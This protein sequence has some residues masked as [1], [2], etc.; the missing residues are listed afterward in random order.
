LI[1]KITHFGETNPVR[2]AQ[3]RKSKYSQ[4]AEYNVVNRNICDV[5]K[6]YHNYYGCL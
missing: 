2:V 6:D 1:T 4:V 3:N 5:Q